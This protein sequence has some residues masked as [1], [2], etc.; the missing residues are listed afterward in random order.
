M[1]PGFIS[2]GHSDNSTSRWHWLKNSRKPN[3]DG[4][5]FENDGISWN[6]HEF[7]HFWVHFHPYLS[8]GAASQSE[9]QQCSY[10]SPSRSAASRS[11]SRRP[12]RRRQLCW[13]GRSCK[14]RDC[15]FLHPEGRATSERAFFFSNI[16]S[17]NWGAWAGWEGNSVL[18]KVSL[19]LS[20]RLSS[21][22]MN[23][24]R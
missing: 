22:L 23:I 4:L 17:E 20:L 5:P 14:R 18:R 7:P 9:S 19:S 21:D 11:R 2:L 1:T 10:R 13:F 24:Y 12:L 3:V 15:Y 8:P 16:P 6:F